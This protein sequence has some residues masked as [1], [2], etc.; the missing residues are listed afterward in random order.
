MTDPIERLI[1]SWLI[2]HGYGEDAICPICLGDMNTEDAGVSLF[3]CK[4]IA[5][6]LH[7]RCGNHPTLTKCPTCREP[8]NIII[9]PAMGSC[10]WCDAHAFINA[11]AL[12]MHFATLHAE[13]LY[14]RHLGASKLALLWTNP[15]GVNSRD[16]YDAIAIGR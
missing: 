11:D 10:I 8:R 3:A 9:T 13:N 4:T 7:S 12:A 15:K 16:F 14:V 1:T 5:H 6:Q 2:R